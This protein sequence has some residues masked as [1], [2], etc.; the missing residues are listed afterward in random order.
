MNGAARK[1]G[2]AD[3]QDGAPRATPPTPPRLD[4]HA[5]ITKKVSAARFRRIRFLLGMVSIEWFSGQSECG[6]TSAYQTVNALSGTLGATRIFVIYVAHR[7]QTRIECARNTKKRNNIK[8]RAV[9]YRCVYSV[10]AGSAVAASA[11]GAVAV[12]PFAATGDTASGEAELLSVGAAAA[13]AA[14]IHS[15]C[16]RPSSAGCSVSSSTL[17]VP[18][19][20]LEEDVSNEYAARRRLVPHSED[21]L[22]NRLVVEDGVKTDT[23]SPQSSRSGSPVSDGSAS[24]VPEEDADGSQKG[25]ESDD[26]GPEDGDGYEDEEVEEGYVPL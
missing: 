15:R 22:P 6:P 19:T 1:E 7:A 17:L 23:T 21:R 13:A 12:V 10:A 20:A 14:C 3:A 2:T 26:L 4:G 24:T 9:Q 8:E 25:D 5:T 18:R 16:E 11:A